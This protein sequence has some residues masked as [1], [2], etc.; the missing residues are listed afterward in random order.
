MM[1]ATSRKASRLVLWCSI[2]AIFLGCTFTLASGAGGAAASGPD[3]KKTGNQI[4]DQISSFA[5][6]AQS[7]YTAALAKAADQYSKAMSAVSVQVSGEPEPVQSAAFASVSNAYFGAIAGAQQV[8]Q[9]A[10]ANVVREATPA[11]TGGYLD[12]TKVQSLAQRNLDD[13]VK[14]ARDQYEQAKVAIGVMDAIPPTPSKNTQGLLEQA[15][16]NYYAGLG[17]AHDR[18]NEFLASASAAARSWTAATPTPTPAN[19]AEKASENWDW[20]VAQVS[21]KVY[22]APSPTP[23]WYAHYYS[24]ATQAP[25][26]VQSLVSEL[27][28]GKEP[29]Y[30][31]SVLAQLAA[32]YSQATA[33]VGSA[34]TEATQAV[35]EIFDSTAEAL[36][37]AGKAVFEHIGEM[38]EKIVD[39]IGEGKKPVEKP[40]K[41]EL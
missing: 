38:K 12:W 31:E 25:A 3:A 1:A 37:N 16:L 20:L 39:T 11:P 7:A 21:D 10:K 34:Y 36:G 41:D 35:D 29:S 17:L 9:K 33:T 28:V 5:E 23:A 27:L 26:A 32:A 24:Q 6:A 8:F 18:Y 15:K 13:S 19:L 2:L 40:V 14:W 22:G 4:S 30:R